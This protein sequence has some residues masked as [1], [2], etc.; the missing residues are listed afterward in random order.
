MFGAAC[1]DPGACAAAAQRGGIWSGAKCFYAV[2]TCRS[3]IF[4]L[5][6]MTKHPHTTKTH[7]VSRTIL[8]AGMLAALLVLTCAGT[9]SAAGQDDENMGTV[10]FRGVVT[11][12]PAIGAVGAGGVNVQIDEILSDPTGNLTINDVVTVG[13]PIVPHFADISAAMGNRVEVCGEY[14]DIEEM[15]DW[16]SG[17]GE[18]WVWLHASDHFYRPLPPT[19]AASSATGAPHDRYP[20]YEDVYVTGSGFTA[21]TDV[22]IIVVMD[23]DWNDGDSIHSPDVVAVSGGTISTSGTVGPVLVWHAP[24]VIGEYDVM[25]DANQNGIYNVATDGLDRG[26]PG[27]AV[28]TDTPPTLPVAVP[29]LT[30]IGITALISLLCVIGTIIIRR[31]FN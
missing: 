21:G 1:G 18:H 19:A 22:H 14:R 11:G 16:W 2:A 3:N 5:S 27:F 17:V 26:S 23:R 31:R 28:I 15:P 8:S 13:Y 7:V 29:A 20:D 25:I 4:E 12:E 6:I 30:P 9:A 10:K 24:L